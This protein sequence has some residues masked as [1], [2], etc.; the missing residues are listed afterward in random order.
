MRI[1]AHNNKVESN[2]QPSQSVAFGI[3]DVSVVIDILRNKLY[4]YKIRTLVQEYMSN[5]RDAH[6]EVGQTKPIKVTAPTQFDPTFR[7]R[8]FGPGVSPDRIENVFV[9]YGASTK[10]QSNKQT[11]GF[12]IGAKSAWAYADSFT[13]TTYIDGTLRRYVAHTGSDKVGR[14]D[15]IETAKTSEVNGTLIEIAVN[16]RD[17][18]EFQVSV[19]RAALFWS[20]DETPE[21]LNV[22]VLNAPEGF[23]LGALTVFPSSQWPHQM[24]SSIGSIGAFV[25]DGIPYPIEDHH[26]EL[27]PLIESVR[28]KIQG[29]MLITIPNG[30]VQVSASR[31]K[32]DDSEV[33]RKGLQRVFTKINTELE[34]YINDRMQAIDS[35]ETFAKTYGELYKFFTLRD[36][37]YK[38]F[39]FDG[40]YLLSD[41][42]KDV[43]LWVH[44]MRRGKLYSNVN[45]SGIMIE[46]F[47]NVYFNPGTDTKVN[48]NRRIRELLAKGVKQVLVLEA[49]QTPNAPT[50]LKTLK[51]MFPL[52][53]FLALPFTVPPRSPKAAKLIKQASQQT[54]H[55]LS[56]SYKSVRY[57]T[58]IGRSARPNTQVWI[59]LDTFHKDRKRIGN[60]IDW[61]QQKKL[62]FDFMAV[63]KA[64][65]KIL[66]DTENFIEFSEWLKGL[67]IDAKTRNGM[68]K[69]ARKCG[70]FVEVLKTI[71]IKNK[72][73]TKMVDLYKISESGD[74]VPE[75]VEKLFKADDK[76][77][78]FLELDKELMKYAKA[79]PLLETMEG[80]HLARTDKAELAFYVK[81]KL[82]SIGL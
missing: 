35:V 75:E 46:E 76:F 77:Q 26:T 63:S 41:L 52:K 31:E 22:P 51:K 70:K 67:T 39:K 30:I 50:A 25:I 73:L 71:D 14:L 19:A 68:V 8:D 64:T 78:E 43:N 40:R 24:H 2:F 34:K 49:G 60:I 48:V 3:G 42:F 1:A 61:A 32:L 74:Y 33:T 38:G 10:R 72:F 59:E 23:D 28:D 82:D 18:T 27:C 57:D 44:T 15:L 37:E 4:E 5:A 16:P 56:G 17:V 62:G 69:N 21:L 6:R 81:A 9:L 54:F 12:G 29:R 80:Y 65:G 53:D 47:H 55:D 45:R 13:I 36:A 79:L 20:S 66:A 7:V 58:A 11:G